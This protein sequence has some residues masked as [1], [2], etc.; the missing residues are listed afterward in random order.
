VDVSQ[1]VRAFYNTYPYPPEPLLDMPPLGWNWRWSWATVHQRYYGYL[2]ATDK[3]Q[4]L[5]AGC[6][7]GFGSQYLGYQNPHSQVWAVDLSDVALGVAEERC[8]RAEVTN[9]MFNQGSLLETTGSYQFINCVGVLHHLPDPL[10]GLKALKASLA[11]GGLMHIFVYSALGRR[12]VALVQEALRMLGPKNATEGVRL[13]RALFK[14]LPP[15]NP[16]VQFE[17]IHWAM[18]NREDSSF[19]DMY[20]QVQ[21]T[22]F[23][24]PTLLT[25]IEQAGLTLVGF[26]NPEFWQLERLLGSNPTLLERAQDLSAPQRWRLIE[27]LD[28]TANHYEF[29]VASA[30]ITPWHPTDQELRACIAHRSPYIGRW[31]GTHV[32]NYRYQELV[33]SP[34]QV[35]WLQDC[36]GQP[37]SQLD[38]LSLDEIRNLV[39]GG[40][41]LLERHSCTPVK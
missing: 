41:V 16:L 10:A 14:T 8:R 36:E 7:T 5:D 38:T 40:L 34:E 19:A 29:F 6:G 21:E 26:S 23:T 30:P 28:P 22:C 33:L 17:K 39:A 15:D 9:V 18:E 3:I 25:W 11:P 13:G 24:I 27:V 35:A 2:P 12:E 20:L 31:P 37:I 1:Q 32:F 4:I